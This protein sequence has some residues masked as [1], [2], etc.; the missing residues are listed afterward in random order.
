MD[1]EKANLERKYENLLAEFNEMKTHSEQ[2]NTLL[3]TLNTDLREE[4]AK[5]VHL[6]EEKRALQEHNDGARREADL[7]VESNAD[8]K[9]QI[10]SLLTQLSEAQSAESSNDR[11]NVVA[12]LSKLMEAPDLVA[13]M[14]STPI[15]SVLESVSPPK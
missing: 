9:E 14:F 7:L 12:S 8:L 3:E 4:K 1:F 13:T 11:I 6:E 10:G 5:V 15:M 2:Y